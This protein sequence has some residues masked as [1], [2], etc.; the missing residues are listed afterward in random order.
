MNTTR[1]FFGFLI[2]VILAAFVLPATADSS[3]TYTLVGPSG[4]AFPATSI[5]TGV[6]GPFTIG[7]KNNSP[8][9]SSNLNSF[10]LTAPPGVTIQ[11][12]APAPTNT[13]RTSSFTFD[14][15]TITVL[16]INP[17][18]SQSAQF[19]MTVS[20]VGACTGGGQWTAIVSG[21]S[22]LQ[23]GG[24][25]FSPNPPTLP[26]TTISGGPACTL[27]FVTGYVPQDATLS[28]GVAYVTSVANTANGAGVRVGAYYTV[29]NTQ[30]LDSTFTGAV[31]M[32][33][34]TGPASL[35]QAATVNAIG[36]VAT[37][38]NSTGGQPLKLAVGG[39]YTLK[40]QATG[41]TDSP[42]APV[43]IGNG[44]LACGADIPLSVSLA[45]TSLSQTDPNLKTT[46]GYA[47][48]K[49]QSNNKDG[50][51]CYD[52]DYSFVNGTLNSTPYVQ[53]RWDTSTPPAGQPNAAFSY[54]A[55]Y[56]AV[57]IQT[58]DT[59]SDYNGGL[60][61]DL[62]P[63]LTWEFDASGAPINLR[64]G[65]ACLNSSAPAPYGKLSSSTSSPD[66]ITIDQSSPPTGG[67]VPLP[68][69][70]SFP[71]VVG[72]ERMQATFSSSAGNLFTFTVLR[73]QGGTSAVNLPDFYGKPVMSTP[74]PIDN[75][76]L[77]A[78]NSTA[79]PSYQKQAH[80]CVIDDGWH[81]YTAD[82]ITGKPRAYFSLSVFDIGDG[83]LSLQ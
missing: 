12:A 32:V 19:D 73:A 21:G 51:I 49:R 47:A 18:V 13:Y 55:N 62:L 52:V 63:V 72:T 77:L 44:T 35:T 10:Q 54:T 79:N 4:S 56:A 37:F 38:G 34:A 69:T 46:P 70:Y 16:G 6:S 76:A 61:P 26:I 82:P 75:N 24:Q 57:P 20:L 64:Y 45:S 71:L 31:S 40:A 25:T 83:W 39:A 66:T 5:S 59:A 60:P 33:V 2:A 23:Q 11:S 67:W 8:V 74:L 80:M 81:A 29:N 42:A 78:D 48:G 14:A 65:I 15:K 53:L 36:G 9:S 58:D 28:N 50:S 22:Q 3:K 17:A 1:K 30:V 68:T 27:Q 43:F 7:V 41:L